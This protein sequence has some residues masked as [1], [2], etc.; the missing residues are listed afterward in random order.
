VSGNAIAVS[1][2]TLGST[3]TQNQ[4]G[5]GDVFL[6]MFDSAGTNG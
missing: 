3:A 2:L 5:A 6:A 1:G 4:A